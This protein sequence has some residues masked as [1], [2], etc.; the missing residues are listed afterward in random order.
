[1]SI[2]IRLQNLPLEA[3][4]LDI[5]RFFQGLQIPD[6]GVHIVG[7]ENGDAFIAFANDE[8][9][10]Q[11]MER[12]GNLIKGSRIKLLLSS[13]NEM[14]RVIDAARNQTISILPSSTKTTMNP[15][16]AAAA[17]ASV[18]PTN[19][20]VQ[21]SSPQKLPPPSSSSI[22]PQQYPTH[23]IGNYP[24][25]QYPPAV[26]IQP[27]LAS[28]TNP[29]ATSGYYPGGVGPSQTVRYPPPPPQSSSQTQPQSQP[30]PNDYQRSGPNVAYGHRQNDR[31]E[32]QYRGRSRSR[33]RSPPTNR[34]G[35]D[36]HPSMNQRYSDMNKNTMQ[37]GLIRSL[38]P[39]VSSSTSQ[40]SPSSSTQIHSS[41]F[42]P[43]TSGNNM[44][45][46]Y[47]NYPQ[48]SQ[49]QQQE[50]REYQSQQSFGGSQYRPMPGASNVNNNT[51]MDGSLG[52]GGGDRGIVGGT[53]IGQQGITIQG[54]GVVGG[55]WNNNNDNNNYRQTSVISN[56]FNNRKMDSIHQ[57]PQQQ[58]PQPLSSA[59]GQ[60]STMTMMPHQSQQQQQQQQQLIRP[61]TSQQ[62]QQQPPP[63]Q[64][65]TL[66]LN[67]LPFNVK[68]LDLIKFFQPL[69]L[70]EDNIKIF[71]DSKGFPTGIALV[72]FGSPKEWEQALT[73]NNRYMGD[74]RIQVQPLDDL[75][76]NNNN[77]NSN[78]GQNSS[79]IINNN[80]N[81]G[82]LLQQPPP[83][84]LIANPPPS[85]SS[86]STTIGQ[87]RK[88]T[89][90]PP[91][92]DPY[93]SSLDN[94][95]TY[96]NSPEEIGSFGRGP[97]PPSSSSSSSSSLQQSSSQFNG[98]MGP[99]PPSSSSSQSSSSSS[100]HHNSSNHHHH[101]HH[102]GKYQPRCKDNALFMKG[103]PFANCTTKDVAHFFDPIKLFHIEIEFDSR[104]KP[105]GNAYVEFHDRQDVDLAMNY[106]MRNMGHRYIELIPW[107]LYEKF[108]PT[109]HLPSAPPPPKFMRGNN[110]GG[111]RGGGPPPPPPSYGGSGGGNHHHHQGP[112]THCVLVRGLG[113][114]VSTPD[115]K[116]FF[117]KS[118]I[119]TYAVHIM[120]TTDKMNAGEAFVEFLTKEDQNR[121]LDMS[122][123]R[124]SGE[125][126]NI[127]PV[128]Y[129]VVR[130]SVPPPRGPPSASGMPSLPPNK[131]HGGKYRRGGPGPRGGNNNN[132]QSAPIFDKSSI[133][134]MK[135][136]SF[137]TNIDDLCRFFD[138]YHI[139]PNRI[140]IRPSTS[141][142]SSSSSSLNDPNNLDGQEAQIQFHSRL[143]AEHAVRTLDKQ[144]LHDRKIYLTFL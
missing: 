6:G 126:V 25:T 13:R 118:N 125:R 43:Q 40:I 74:R 133:L 127:R 82:P 117:A 57:L 20:P 138:D 46:R 31:Q 2:I 5:R 89:L 32:L 44:D 68:S 91:Q 109:Y 8:D 71:Y 79:T 3:N 27:S 116:Q 53:G 41:N 55:G 69:Y 37:T 10:R 124:L 52:G 15:N 122:G 95:P 81:N 54:G 106:N 47:T 35:S 26:Q 59:Y 85:N 99:P 48:P 129:E 9:A 66:Q 105:T 51:M 29:V 120:L 72:R 76:N 49:Q 1:M 61:P 42:V 132:G 77:N 83:P 141:N 23:P 17:A 102:R 63:Q 92:S 136:I 4:S 144:Y 114:H 7:G 39:S 38:Q 142:D 100:H 62:Q 24:T 115:L 87:Q 19:I 75:G 34:T 28:S 86:A 60:P 50:S 103:L 73:F 14:Q 94:Y 22:Q 80:N 113:K 45:I 56:D 108:G 36:I 16:A 97:P 21:Q 30:T 123:A 90:P 101:H 131:S 143:D 135:N 107:I 84:P 70:D 140:K 65:F 93:R 128:A 33:S 96:R 64:M 130:A 98:G 12:N 121:A 104:N 11:A 112:F 134:L 119:D 18:V 139:T 110:S 111:S 67:D 78:I 58:Q 137:K 88:N